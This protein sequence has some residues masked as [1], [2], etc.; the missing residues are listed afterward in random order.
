MLQKQSP[1]VDRGFFSTLYIHYSGCLYL[2]AIPY[3]LCFVQLSG[4][5]DLTCDFRGKN[6]KNKMLA[7]ETQWNQLFKLT[8]QRFALTVAINAHGSYQPGR[9]GMEDTPGICGCLYDHCAA[10]DDDD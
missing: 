2:F 10:V 4:F 3:P 5:W 6:A 8:L 7:K 9:Y 1:G